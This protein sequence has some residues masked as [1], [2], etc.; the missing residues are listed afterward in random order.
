M[1]RHRVVVAHL[2]P[3]AAACEARLE[4][5]LV[6]ARAPRRAVGVRRGARA[7]RAALG[8]VLRARLGAGELLEDKQAREA[9]DARDRAL[10][11][12]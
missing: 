3:P 6:L 10:E 1:Q 12:L 2:E 8:E 7:Q 9:L 5:A 11:D 4:I